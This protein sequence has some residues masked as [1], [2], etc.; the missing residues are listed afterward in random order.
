MKRW[1]A[2]FLCLVFL[3]S[4]SGCAEGRSAAK[5]VLEVADRLHLPAGS[6]CFPHAQPNEEGY[7]SPSL[8]FAL[9]GT[10]GEELLAAA[11]DG[12]VYLGL[13]L[14]EPME[15][16][17]LSFST[18]AGA[19]QAAGALSARLSAL[20]RLSP[21]SPNLVGAGVWV[22]KNAV[23]YTVLPDNEEARQLL[24]RLV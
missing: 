9:F 14:E 8:R 2:F 10:E 24:S 12:A 6:L 21:T 22:I 7:L 23:F 20:R 11:R 3:F 13:G 4:L 18:H 19:R 16:A 17:L 1:C 15:F 5:V